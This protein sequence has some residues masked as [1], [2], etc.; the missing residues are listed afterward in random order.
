MKTASVHLSCTG[1]QEPCNCPPHG[2][3]IICMRVKGSVCVCACI[4]LGGVRRCAAGACQTFWYLRLLTFPNLLLS[5]VQVQAHHWRPGWGWGIVAPYPCV[6][7]HPCLRACDL[8]K[9]EILPPARV[10]L[11]A[12]KGGPCPGWCTPVLEGLKGSLSMN[13]LRLMFGFPVSCVGSD[14]KIW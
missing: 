5:P 4:C 11:G 1:G 14:C 8:L 6:P 2:P 10:M 7:K 13:W 9:E 12:A 3:A